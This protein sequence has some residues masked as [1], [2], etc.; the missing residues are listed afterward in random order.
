MSKEFNEPEEKEINNSVQDAEIIDN[1]NPL[2]EPINEKEYT[3]H[4]VRY[5]AKDMVGDIPEP[6]LM[7]PPMGDMMSQ[8]EKI[9]KPIEPIN[10]HLSD[11]SNKDKHDASEKVAD[12]IITGYKF[13]WGFADSKLLFDDRKIRKLEEEGQIDLGIDVPIGNGQTMTAGEF[14]NEYNEQSKGTL[15]VSQEFEDE[16][17]PPLVR[18]L[19]KR[20]IGM[21]DMQ[22]I[23]YIVGKDALTKTFMAYQS[24]SVKKDILNQLIEANQLMKGQ[25]KMASTPPPP[26]PPP[27]P[28]Y[29]APPP[30]PPTPKYKEPK[31]NP[32]EAPDVNEIVKKMTGSEILEEEFV[33]EYQEDFGDLTQSEPIDTYEEPKPKVEIITDGV[34]KPIGKKGRP[35]KK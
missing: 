20:G 8:E 4:N 26:P 2:D 18:E 34:K 5:N 13:A 28:T 23:W 29:Q 22:Q 14:I 15:I 19:K 21:T 30:P 35:K 12:M 27:T 9:K 31:R 6:S 25:M 33:D 32:N 7:P 24:M 1:F 16:L 17:N 11:L 10:T 3:K